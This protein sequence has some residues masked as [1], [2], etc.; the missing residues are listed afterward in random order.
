VLEVHAAATGA[1]Q[2]V[3]CLSCKRLWFEVFKNYLNWKWKF[4]VE[5]GGHQLQ[6]KKVTCLIVYPRNGLRKEVNRHRLLYCMMPLLWKEGMWQVVGVVC[7]AVW[8]QTS[9]EQNES[10]NT[11]SLSAAMCLFISDILKLHSCS[12]LFMF[13]NGLIPYAWL[14]IAKCNWD[15]ILCCNYI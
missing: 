7:Q 14:A 9:P 4:T 6:A 5:V 13:L 8:H 3:T 12:F 11:C 1:L 2:T 15:I 10:G